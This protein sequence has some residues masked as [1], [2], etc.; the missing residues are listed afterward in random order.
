MTNT[1][2]ITE[3]EYRTFQDAYSFFNAKLFGN[4]LPDL[5]VTLQRHAGAKG[6]MYSLRNN[7]TVAGGQLEQLTQSLVTGS[8]VVTVPKG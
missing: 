6:I 8:F 5:L 7:D 3:R 1:N 4:S 2:L